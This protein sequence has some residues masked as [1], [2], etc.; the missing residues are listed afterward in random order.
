[1]KKVRNNM[2]SVLFVCT[3]NI[4]RSPMAAGLLTAI[5]GPESVRNWRIESAGTWAIKGETAAWK[6]LEVLQSRGIDARGHRSRP[7]DVDLLNSF[8]LILTME[9]G[10]KEALRIEFPQIAKRVFTLSELSGPAYDLEDPIGG[11]T[12][13]FE[14]TAREIDELI[15]RGF[16]R[17]VQLSEEKP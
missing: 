1:V 14:A 13:D 2:H 9:K 7:V 4:C 6:T 17:L 11:S 12:A 3:A 8:Q 15:R 5:L 16:D 10:Q